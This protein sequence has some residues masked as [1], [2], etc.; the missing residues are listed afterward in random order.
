[1]NYL[2]AGMLLIGVIYAAFTGRLPDITTEV[3]ASAK[4]AV[5]L[6][7]TMLGVM[8]FWMGLM[9]IAE[10]AGMIAGFT[11]KLRPLLRFLFPK[12]PFCLLLL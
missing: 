3:L 8:S 2:W 9:K 10:Q 11:K 7:V 1:M 5:T 12:N 4:E 6:C